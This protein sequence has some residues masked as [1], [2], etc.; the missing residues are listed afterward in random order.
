[1]D[2]FASGQFLP[3]PMALQS[4]CKEHYP[5]EGIKQRPGRFKDEEIHIAN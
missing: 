1:V 5:W 4:C 3:A 2:E